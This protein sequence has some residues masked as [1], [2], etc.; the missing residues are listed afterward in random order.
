MSQCDWHVIFSFPWSDF[1]ANLRPFSHLLSPK[2]GSRKHMWEVVVFALTGQF[3]VST[4]KRTCQ[5]FMYFSFL[6]VPTGQSK[7][8]RR[9][10]AVKEKECCSPWWTFCLSVSL[11][12]SW[13]TVG[14]TQWLCLEGK[15]PP[16]LL[17]TISCNLHCYYLQ[18]DACCMDSSQ[19]ESHPLYSLLQS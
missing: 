15:L 2:R 14:I 1:P 8:E 17:N 10:E 13:T 5:L 3:I 16:G 4:S 18:R 19:E 12:F 11:G 6:L 7:S 9:A